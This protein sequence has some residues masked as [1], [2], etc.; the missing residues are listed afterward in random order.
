MLKKTRKSY[1]KAI[2]TATFL[3][4]DHPKRYNR[5]NAN[6]LFYGQNRKLR[7]KPKYFAQW[8]R[9]GFA[10]HKRTHVTKMKTRGTAMMMVGYAL[11]HPSGTYEFYNPNTD[12]II[13]SNFVKWSVLNR[14]EA[15]NVDSM[16]GKLYDIKSDSQKED[17]ADSDSGDDFENDDYIA[18]NH[19]L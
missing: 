17:L 13:I 15:A 7:V 14:W 12:S 10:T 4:E 9:I 8:G 18:T 19:W 3:H 16:S 11:N 1:A 6:D 5:P 2:E